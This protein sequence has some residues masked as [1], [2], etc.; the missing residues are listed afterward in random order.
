MYKLKQYVVVMIV[1]QAACVC[2]SI[3]PTQKKH[4]ETVKAA[5]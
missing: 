1:Y 2:L 4:E 3:I 5:D